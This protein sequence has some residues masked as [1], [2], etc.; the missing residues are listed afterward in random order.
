MREIES[1]GYITRDEDVTTNRQTCFNCGWFKYS[2][3]TKGY[4]C[5]E[6]HSVS[7]QDWRQRYAVCDRWRRKR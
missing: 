1:D 5:T 4:I 2:I 6:G 7:G 3:E